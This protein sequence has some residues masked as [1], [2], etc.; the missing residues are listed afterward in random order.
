V[1]WLSINKYVPPT[2]ETMF[3]RASNAEDHIERYFVGFTDDLPNIKDLNSWELYPA[4]YPDL[5]LDKYKVTHFAILDAVEI[6]Q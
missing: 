1:K 2:G 3:I 4:L 5:S 6:E